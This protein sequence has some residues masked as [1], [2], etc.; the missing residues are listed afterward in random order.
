VKLGSATAAVF[1]PSDRRGKFEKLGLERV[2]IS[3][4]QG[5]ERSEQRQRQRIKREKESN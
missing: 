4:E 5:R 1:R 2:P 3:D